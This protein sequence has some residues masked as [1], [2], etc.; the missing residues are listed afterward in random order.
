[1][2][3]YFTRENFAYI[4]ITFGSFFLRIIDNLADL[5]YIA[6]ATWFSRTEFV[7]SVATF[8]LGIALIVWGSNVSNFTQYLFINLRVLTFTLYV[9]K[10]IDDTL[11]TA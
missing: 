2:I 11:E 6:T 9:E 1:V 10:I 8:F 3:L 4:L 7:L 5:N